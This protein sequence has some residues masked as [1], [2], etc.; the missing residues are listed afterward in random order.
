MSG[1]SCAPWCVI[2]LIAKQLDSLR[3]TGLVDDYY[4][5]F[6]E[7]S[8]HIQLYNQ[9]YDHVFF[10]TRFLNGIRDEIRSVITLHCPK[11]VETACALALLQ[12]TE[13]ENGKKKLPH[14]YDGWFC[15]DLIQ[16]WVFR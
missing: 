12:E 2:V 14:N 7:L 5:R 11:D 1:I 4:T 16:V 13:L 8:H 15:E 9:A 10:V 3:Q 6:V